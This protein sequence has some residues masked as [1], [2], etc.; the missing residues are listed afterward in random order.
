[1]NFKYQE[2]PS[3][4]SQLYSKCFQSD[5]GFF[6]TPN[7]MVSILIWHKKKVSVASAQALSAMICF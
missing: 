1:M 2:R 5:V 6:S 4:S 3:K 7:H